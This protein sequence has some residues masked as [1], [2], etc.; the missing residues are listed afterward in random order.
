MLRIMLLL[1]VISRSCRSLMV[2]VCR[3][4]VHRCVTRLVIIR[5]VVLPPLSVTVL[6]VSARY[7]RSSVSVPLRLLVGMGVISLNSPRFV[8]IRRFL[9]ISIPLSRVVQGAQIGRV[10][11]VLTMLRRE[12]RLD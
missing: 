4:T 5:P 1:S 2:S 9:R 6:W 8:P 7:V 12:I 10:M 11:F 3:R